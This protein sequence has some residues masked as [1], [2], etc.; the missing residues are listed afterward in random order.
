V[1]STA[2]T[3]GASAASNRRTTSAASTNRTRSDD[4]LAPEKIRCARL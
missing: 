4:Q 1:S 2:S 3:I